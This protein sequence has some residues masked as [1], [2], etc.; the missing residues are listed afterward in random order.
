MENTEKM[1]SITQ[2][3]YEEFLRL[4]SKDIPMQVK[5]INYCPSCEQF[6]GVETTRQEY[7]DNCGQALL[8]EY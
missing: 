1:V 6:L 4:V 5:N 3:Q 7:C 2:E 8:W